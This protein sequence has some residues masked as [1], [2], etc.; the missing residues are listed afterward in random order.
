MSASRCEW[1]TCPAL[2]EPEGGAAPEFEVT[3]ARPSGEL[4]CLVCARC[5]AASVQAALFGRCEPA[6]SIR[7]VSLLLGG[8]Q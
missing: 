7:V 8:C 3:I 4:R 1:M 6:L 5:A 2:S